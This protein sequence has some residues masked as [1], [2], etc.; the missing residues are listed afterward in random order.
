MV[1]IDGTFSRAEVANFNAIQ[2]ILFFPWILPVV[3]H[4]K[5]IVKIKNI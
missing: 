4:I 5:I 2:I 1:S 3:I